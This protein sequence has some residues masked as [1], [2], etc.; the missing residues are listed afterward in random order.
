MIEEVQK[1]MIALVS[2][3]ET[4][5]KAEFPD[6]EVMML[7]DSTCM[8]SWFALERFGTS[9]AERIARDLRAT[10]LKQKFMQLCRVINANSQIA[11][12][13][14]DHIRHTLVLTWQ[15]VGN[16]LEA[17]KKTLSRYTSSSRVQK[18][19]SL[20]ELRKVARFA[21]ARKEN[22]QGVEGNFGEAE[23]QSARRRARQDALHL[24]DRMTIS[25]CIKR[26]E[27][28]R[29]TREP[30]QLL[31]NSL[32]LYREFFGEPRGQYGDPKLG[33]LARGKKRCSSAVTETSLVRGQCRA[34]ESLAVSVPGG[35]SMFGATT[36]LPTMADVRADGQVWTKRHRALDHAL[37]QK[38][39]AKIAE[40]TETLGQGLRPEANAGLQTKAKAQAKPK[41]APKPKPEPKP[42]LKP[43]PKRKRQAKR[44]PK[45]VIEK[46]KWQKV[47][48]LRGVAATAKAQ[49][50]LAS[51][52]AKIWVHPERSERKTNEFSGFGHRVVSDLNIASIVVV[53]KL[54]THGFP[55]LHAMLRGKHL[56]EALSKAAPGV[57]YSLPKR[58]QCLCITDE[59]KRRQPR[60]AREIE[61]ACSHIPKWTFLHD[62][63]SLRPVLASKGHKAGALLGTADEAKNSFKVDG[64]VAT[65]WGDWAGSLARAEQPRL[66]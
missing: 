12:V 3:I 26:G 5:I 18:R 50:S 52:D 23:R 19:Q 10:E 53:Q 8:A 25:L 11:W 62:P 56:V 21:A 20:D 64:L 2:T 46:L 40:A 31:W 55:H 27:L 4:Y 65:F 34:V 58:A 49:T 14:F 61:E 47:L 22:T 33:T 39:F 66:A 38:R 51:D 44:L 41:P 37:Q 7:L 24:R 16:N 43:D 15:E 32:A 59:L 28:L 30:A 13:Q 29:S 60:V 36:A 57:Q 9:S 1:R 45:R 48:Q 6:Q 35:R 17:W 63:A 54:T 42:K